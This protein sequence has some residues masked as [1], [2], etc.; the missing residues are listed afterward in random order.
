MHVVCKWVYLLHDENMKIKEKILGVSYF[1]LFIYG[2]DSVHHA[3]VK[4]HIHGVK[5]PD[6][7]VVHMEKENRGGGHGVRDKG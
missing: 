1:F 4:K 3:F 6:I 2:L 5:I 7:T